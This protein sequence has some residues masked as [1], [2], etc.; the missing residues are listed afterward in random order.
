MHH[1]HVKESNLITAY[2]GKLR[3]C[4]NI[5]IKAELCSYKTI[6]IFKDIVG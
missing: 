1:A 6:Y 2:S 5:H 3:V 4:I